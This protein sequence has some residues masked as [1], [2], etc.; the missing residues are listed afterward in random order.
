[1]SFLRDS[2]SSLPPNNHHFLLVVKKE[3]EYPFSI[4]EYRPS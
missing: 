1:M 3:M 2:S 4:I